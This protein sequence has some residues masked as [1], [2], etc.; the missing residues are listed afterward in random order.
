[1]L[2]DVCIIV[3]K[4]FLFCLQVIR[5]CLPFVL[6]LIIY[7][8][9]KVIHIQPAI[10]DLG[11]VHIHTINAIEQFLLGFHPH[12]LISAH[13]SI[14][15]DALASVPY[16]MHY[17]LPVV[18]PLYLLLIGKLED[19]TKFYWLLGWVM[20]LSY[21]IWLVFPHT[22]PWVIDNIEQH[23]S[24]MS[25]AMQHKEGCAFARLDAFTGLHFFHNMFNGN[26]IPFGCFPSGHVAWPTIIYMVG[27]PGGNLFICY[28]LWVAWATLYSCHHYLLDAIAAVVVVVVT[29][30][31]LTYL[32]EKNVC[33]ANYK[34]RPSNITC[35]FN[36]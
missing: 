34:C 22:P 33:S 5:S 26:P 1:M 35:P 36:V 19:V 2:L 31:I 30:K 18:F 20:W 29:N 13:H 3:Y 25:L 14:F 9:N 10:E 6:F 16:L 7:A 23:N 17:G 27:A 28:I 24:T 4:P 11:C 8:L 32:A 21:L 15:L 12:K